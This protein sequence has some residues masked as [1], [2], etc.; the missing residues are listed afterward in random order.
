MKRL[1]FGILLL[2]VLAIVGIRL[3]WPT[4]PLPIRFRHVSFS[5]LP[6][7]EQTNPINALRAFQ[8]SCNAFLK[9][10]ATKSVGSDIFDLKAKDWHP[11]CRAALS[12]TSL[13]KQSATTFFQQW[14]SPVEFMD[15]AAVE[16]LFTGYYMPLLQGSLSRT[17]RYTVPLYGLPTNLV[18]IPL[19]L[20]DPSFKR[21][22]LMGRVQGDKVLPYYTREEINQGAI[23]AVA[24]VIA[25]VHSPIDR[26]FLEIQG[27]GLIALPDG[28][29]LSVGYIA[30]NGAPY[31]AIAKIL[32]NKGVMTRD[33]ASMQHIR[34][35]LEGHPEE[36]EVV[37]NQNKSFVFFSVLKNEEALGSQG[38]PLTPGYSLAVDRAWVPL[39]TPVWLSTT[40][41]SEKEGAT[42]AIF[43]RLMVA[44]DTGGAIKGAVRGDVYWGAGERATT[45]AGRMKNKGH[46]WLLLPKRA[47]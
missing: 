21:R 7:W 43:Q 12:M 3:W 27:S 32:I 37:L 40:R 5:A 4:A 24:P 45:I 29:R 47:S 1:L 14:F 22:Q 11:A 36:I 13:S 34:R 15:T 26:S 46:Y 28:R 41:P 23:K 31:T 20:F 6:G 39:G 16:G 33:N 8:I 17:K 42:D 10:S 35:Y 2:V 18:T 19:H 30:E 25:W 9:Q 44:Q 38:V